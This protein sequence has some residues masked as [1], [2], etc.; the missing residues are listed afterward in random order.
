MHAKFNEMQPIPV[1]GVYHKVGVD[2]IGPLQ[3]SVSGNRYI[4]TIIEFMTKNVEAAAVPDKSSNTTAEFL[5]REIICR[6]STPAEVVTDLG[7][8]F[9][10][11]FK[12]L[13]D[14]CGIDHRLI[15]SYHPQASGLTE[16][17]NQTIIR[18]L[19]KMTAE[20]LLSWDKQ[21]PKVLLGYRL[22]AQASTK[23]SP[24]FLLHARPVVLPLVRRH[25]ANLL[26]LYDEV[27]TDSEVAKQAERL[28][29]LKAEA[30]ASI[31]Q[32]HGSLGKEN[33]TELGTLPF[34]GL[35]VAQYLGLPVHETELPPA[36]PSTTTNPVPEA[37]VPK[38]RAEQAAATTV[39][40]LTILNP[41]VS[42]GSPAV[43]APA[44][45]AGPNTAA[46]TAAHPVIE[47]AN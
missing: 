31:R 16:R 38:L 40:T 6:Q 30:R 15:S 33:P 17:A 1:E 45:T 39:R 42:K 34:G 26:P 24:F 14:R 21:I 22:D 44:T 41:T 29:A 47:D 36:A 9:R 3:T 12:A 46:T 28:S 10:G 37:T 23:F 8:E 11:D 7:G 32:M 2:M 20:N 43:I 18:A 27:P 19:V 5:D 4:I 25:R 35:T 13:L